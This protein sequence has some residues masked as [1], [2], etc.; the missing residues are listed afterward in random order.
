MRLKALS[1]YL[2]LCWT[3]AAHAQSCADIYGA[4]RHAA[5]YCGFFCDQAKLRPLQAAYESKCI[6]TFVAPSLFDLDQVADAPTQANHP[7]N[8][9]AQAAR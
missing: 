8:M 1:V 6:P 2:L 5:M 9:T 7:S 3:P 4:I